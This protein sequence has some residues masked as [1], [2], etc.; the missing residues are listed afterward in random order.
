MRASVVP[1]AMRNRIVS[2]HDIIAVTHRASGA[3]D[4]ERYRDVGGGRTA[5]GEG[6][7][8]F[9]AGNGFV[10]VACAA[11]THGYRVV[12]VDNW[13]SSAMGTAYL[14]TEAAH[15][16]RCYRSPSLLSLRYLRHHHR[17]CHPSQQW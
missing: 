14:A 1:A 11:Y 8:Y 15:W 12:I 3:A 7:G 13:D 10:Q 9:I 4:A 6:Y 2:G 16:G 5:G 17:R